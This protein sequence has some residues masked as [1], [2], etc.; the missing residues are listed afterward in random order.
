MTTKFNIGDKVVPVSKTVWGCLDSSVEWHKAKEVNQP[1]L[2]VNKVEG[3]TILCYHKDV[4]YSTGDYFAEKDLVLY[5]TEND[6]AEITGKL[7]DLTQEALLVVE[8]LKANKVD[9]NTEVETEVEEKPSIIEEA[10]AF[11]K[12]YGATRDGQGHNVGNVTAQ[13][14]FYEAEFVTNEEKGKVTA[15]IYHLAFGQT[16]QSKTPNLVGRATCH[17][18]DVFN[19]H[20]GE[21]I[22]LGRALEINVGKFLEV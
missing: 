11:V 21:A 3:D 16:R 17:K 20:I 19:Q 1:Y 7:E 5:V 14:H 4:E 10:K 8:T 18:N 13:E 2:Y 6:V 12:K 9:F 22:A 15:L